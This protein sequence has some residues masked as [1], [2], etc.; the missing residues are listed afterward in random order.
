[1]RSGGAALACDGHNLYVGAPAE[2]DH[3]GAVYRVRAVGAPEVVIR[4]EAADEL[5]TA[6]VVAGGILYAGAPGPASAPGRVL[7]LRLD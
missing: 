1:M 7:R 4:G 3:A 6:V 2:S 5:G